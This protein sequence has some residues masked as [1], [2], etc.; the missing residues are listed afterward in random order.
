MEY[1]T[2]NCD[3]LKQMIEKYVLKLNDEQHTIY[4]DIFASMDNNL[5]NL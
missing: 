1:M 2:W 3:N 5:K 4:L